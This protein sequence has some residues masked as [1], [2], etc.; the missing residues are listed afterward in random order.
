[1]KQLVRI[2]A[3]LFIFVGILAGCMT[4]IFLLILMV[5]FPLLLIAAVLTCLIFSRLRSTAN[6]TSG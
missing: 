1:M 3:A 2:F 4:A 6:N 5:R